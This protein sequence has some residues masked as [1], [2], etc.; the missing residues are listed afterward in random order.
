MSGA[1]LRAAAAVVGLSIQEGIRRRVFLAVLVLTVGF[2]SLYAL[3]AHFAFRDVGQFASGVPDVLD[4]RAF[5]GATLLGLAMFATLFLG[6]VLAVFLTLG[7][8]RGDAESGLLQPIVVRPLGRTTMLVAR[9]AGAALL[10]AAYVVVVYLAACA[11]IQVTGDWTPDH[12]LGPALGL[13]LAVAIVAALSLL[14]STVL[15]ATAQ[16]IVV[17]MVFG[18]GL[19]AGLMAQIGSAIDSDS[20]HA[21][22]RTASW[23]LPFE[24][25]YAASLHALISQT[26]G[27]TG[28][29]LQLGPF[30][31]SEAAGPGLVAWA[32]VYLLGVLALAAFVFSRRDL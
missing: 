25:L 18:A 10:S 5:T 11:I 21:I 7:V 6:A 12:L 29:V 17:F 30:G 20:L 26:S 4:S 19:T 3:G 23:A 14:A 24:G 27:L 32:F 16:G 15:S 1:Q 31:G 8:V 9:F 13:A 28:V 2:L 22:G